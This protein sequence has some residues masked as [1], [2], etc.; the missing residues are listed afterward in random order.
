M[1]IKSYRYINIVEIP[2]EDKYNLIPFMNKITTLVDDHNKYAE[3][4]S[5]KVDKRDV[6]DKCK[7]DYHLNNLRVTLYYEEYD[8]KHYLNKDVEFYHP[9]KKS[10]YEKCR[11][12][13]ENRLKEYCLK[14][15]WFDDIEEEEMDV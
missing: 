7:I 15:Q 5:D 8:G 11:I 9:V 12:E 3:H 1:K 13:L 2:E 4:K 6:L 10:D 14:H